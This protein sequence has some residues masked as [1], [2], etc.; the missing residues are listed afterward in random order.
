MKIKSFITNIVAISSF[1]GVS[2]ITIDINHLKLQS[3]ELAQKETESPELDNVSIHAD[4]S[5]GY[6]TIKDLKKDA[7]LVVAGNIVEVQYFDFNTNTFTK[8]KVEIT[9]SFNNNAK[10]GDIINVI[11]RGGITTKG[12]LQKYDPDKLNIPSEQFDDEVEVSVDN[13]PLSKIGDNVIVFA[14]EDKEDFFQLNEKNYIILN[15]YEGKFLVQKGTKMYKRHQQDKDV[16]IDKDV[17]MT[18]SELTNKIE[19]ID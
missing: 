13:A 1:I 7:D 12:N 19:A 4:F 6:K 9:K 3:E 10:K 5:K 15:S 8:S 2:Y 14:K 16:N 18:L 11:E 17:E